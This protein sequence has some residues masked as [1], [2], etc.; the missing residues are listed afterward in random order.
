MEEKALYQDSKHYK[1]EVGF[2]GNVMLNVG[3]M[4]GSGILLLPFVTSAY[5]GPYIWLSW[6]IAG[7][8][9]LPVILVYSKLIEMYPVTGGMSRYPYYSHGGFTSF[10]ASINSIFY[11]SLIIVPIEAQATVRYLNLFWPV[12]L[13]S[14]AA[15]TAIG[16]LTEVIIVIVIALVIYYGIKYVSGTNFALTLIKI[17]LVV[18]FGLIMISFFWSPVNFTDPKIAYLPKGIPGIFAAAGMSIFAYIGFRRTAIYAGEARDIKALN[19]TEIVAW[20]IVIVVYIFMTIALIGAINWDKLAPIAQKQGITLYPGNWTGI[21]NL[22]GPFAAMALGFGL[23]WLYYLF[24]LD[25]IISPNGV[26]IVELGGVPRLFYAAAKTKYMPKSLMKVDK[27]TGTPVW[28]LV[29]STIIGIAF[30]FL[31]PLY[32]E[33]VDV[34]IAGSNILFATGPAAVAGVLARK[35]IKSPLYLWIIGPLAMISSSL[36]FYWATFPYTLYGVIAIFVLIPMFYYYV[37]KGEARGD[38]KNGLWYIIY[39]IIMVIISYTGDTTFGG[40]GILSFPY[41]F[42]VIIIVGIV[43]YY[44]AMVSRLPVDPEEAKD[45]EE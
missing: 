32:S 15:P 37:R 22:S 23:I 28:G 17:F 30:L 24:L 42:L 40:L 38:W 25:G 31:I 33:S 4:I 10:L 14:T 12:F 13:T 2:W 43:F 20:A 44:L 21:G 11:Y 3:A 26:S 29:V 27:K 18:L 7:F 39:I 1:K 41:D 16:Y 36:I 19:K 5:A 35:K 9:V 45:I 8:L 6:L 34:L